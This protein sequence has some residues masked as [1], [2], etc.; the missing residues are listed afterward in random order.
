MGQNTNSDD[1]MAWLEQEKQAMDDLAKTASAQIGDAVDL[2]PM[3]EAQAA[4]ANAFFKRSKDDM[5]SIKQKKQQRKEQLEAEARAQEQAH[6]E[7]LERQMREKI[8]EVNRRH[9]IV[10]EDDKRTWRADA[11]E[12]MTDEEYA[13]WY[14][15]YY[16]DPDNPF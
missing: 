3:V 9:G 13:D 15:N 5:L 14:D 11:M 4:E 16:F 8:A 12:H 6:I 1:I 10:Q 7:K 2:K